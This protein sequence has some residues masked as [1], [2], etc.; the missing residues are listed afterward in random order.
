M[1]QAT[2]S[3]GS[4]LGFIKSEDRPGHKNFPLFFPCIGKKKINTTPHWLS[5]SFASGRVK[6]SFSDFNLLEK[7]VFIPDSLSSLFPLT[8]Q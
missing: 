5:N 4:Q 1:E 7:Y 3:S 8:L 6:Y 2:E